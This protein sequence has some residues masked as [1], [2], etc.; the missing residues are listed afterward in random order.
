[1]VAEKVYWRAG[2]SVAQSA[3]CLAVET[4][5]KL[6]GEMAGCLGD[7]S[8]GWSALSTVVR[9]GMRWADSSVES[10]VAKKAEPLVDWKAVKKAWMTAVRSAYHLVAS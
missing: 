7:R 4:A 3:A 9:R 6:A 5:E 1:M 10:L 8:V 2:R